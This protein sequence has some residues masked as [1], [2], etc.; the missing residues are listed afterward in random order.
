MNA[1]FSMTT[2]KY[3]FIFLQKKMLMSKL[4]KAKGALMS[5]EPRISWCA[6]YQKDARLKKVLIH[7]I[8]KFICNKWHVYLKQK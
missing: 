8:N 4:S 1:H 5:M 7:E 6:K 3:E 2:A